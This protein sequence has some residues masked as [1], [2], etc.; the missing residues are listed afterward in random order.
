[1]KKAVTLLALIAWALTYGQSEINLSGWYSDSFLKTT[2]ER[3]ELKKDTLWVYCKEGGFN[4]TY[5]A[6]SVYGCNIDH[7]KRDTHFRIGSVYEKT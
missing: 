6:C 1:M 3:V 7:S 5:I 2:I 4:S